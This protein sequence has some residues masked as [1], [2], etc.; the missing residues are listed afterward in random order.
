MSRLVSRAESFERVYEAFENINFAAFDFNT[1][2]QSI[3]D[4]VK[5][6]FP[7]SFNDFIETSEFIALVESFAYIAEQIAYRL[8]INA[9]EN[10][11]STAQRRDSIL[12]LAKL[13][14]YTASRPIP[15]R[16]FT[17][18]SSV[19]TTES[20]VDANG[21]D[22]AGVTIV[23]NDSSNPNWK[24]QFI[25]VINRVLEQEFGTVGPND[26]FQIQDVLFEL[27]NV[28][29]V[30]LTNGVFKYSAN[31]NGSTTPMELVPVEFDSSQGI[32]ERRPA[33]N[34]NFTLLYASDGLGDASETTGFLTL[35]KQG[36]LQRFRTT[37]DGVTPNQFY[38]VTATNV[39]D[40][41]VWL[42][43]VDPS[44][45]E[46]LDLPSPISFRP[47]W[48]G[49]SGEWI[50]VDLA[51]S[52][53]VIFNTNPNRNKYEVETRDNSAVRLIFGDGEFADIPAGTFDIWVRT[54]VNEDIV[55]AQASV[56]NT[57][58]SF[59][60]VDGL[61]R[62]QTFTFTYTLIGSLQNA[63]AAETLDHIRVT[64]PS[65]Y[66]TQDRMVNAEDYNVFML[67]DP[68]ILK[69]RAINRTFAG[70]S[71]YIP[72]HD[73]RESYENVKLFGDDG[74]LYYEQAPVSQVTSI[75]SLDALIA[76]F[77]E[78][79]LSSTDLLT[80]LMANGV[81]PSQIRTFFTT[82]E[83]NRIAA[84]L[85]TPP[86]PVEALLYFKKSNTSLTSPAFQW[87]AV[88]ATATVTDPG[89]PP[90]FID[91]LGGVGYPVDFITEALITVEQNDVLEES[92]TV[93]R[94]SLR[95]IFES[96]ETQFWNTNDANAIIDYDTLTSNIDTIT[97]LKANVDFARNSVLSQNW[98]YDVL[99]QETV[100]SGPETGLPDIHR[101]S[102][103]PSDIN[104]DGLPDN[105]DPDAAS[106]ESVA[107]IINYKTIMDVSASIE[108]FTITFPVFY[109]VSGGIVTTPDVTVTSV[110]GNPPTWQQVG[111]P[112]EISNTIEILEKGDGSGY[113]VVDVGGNKT[114]TSLTGL[115]D[116]IAGYQEIEFLPPITGTTLVAGLTASTTYTFTV[117]VD[118][119]APQTISINS[120]DITNY[121]SLIGQ[122]NNDLVG[123]IANIIAGNIR[124]TSN[125]TGA[126]SSI[127]ITDITVFALFASLADPNAISS[128]PV[129][130]TSAFHATV[131][132]PPQ[133]GTNLVAGLT[134]STTYTLNVDVDGGGPQLISINSDDVTDYSSLIFEINDDLTGAV[135]T[136]QGYFISNST[137][138][139]ASVLVT[140]GSFSPL[141]AAITDPH[142]ISSMPVPGIMG[143]QDVLF[144][145]SIIGTD[146]VLGLDPL[147]T[148]TFTVA[149]DSGAPQT[150]SINGA[151]VT[152]Y[153]SL[154]SEINTDLG[155]AATAK[156]IGYQTVIVS[157][158][159][160]GISYTFLS[161]DTYDF[162]VTIDGGPLQQL[163][164]TTTNSPGFEIYVAI[165]ALMNAVVVGGTVTYSDA[166]SA[167]VVTSNSTGPVST[168]L[169]A[170]GT[171]GSTGGD[172]FAAL[173]V[174]DSKTLAFSP[175]V[176]GNIRITSNTIGPLSSIL[177]TDPTTN[178][179][180]F[181]TISD[182]NTIGVAVPGSSTIYTATVAVDGGAP[183]LVSVDGGLAQTYDDLLTEI[184]ADL[185]GAYAV[186]IG[187]N[188]HII[189]NS[190]GL[191]STIA[192]VNINLFSSLTGFIAIDPAVPG[193]AA[194]TTQ[195]QIIVNDYVYF[196][197]ASTTDPWFPAETTF[198]SATSFID[199]AIAGANLWRRNLGRDALNFA[200]FHFAP[201]Y[202]LVDPAPT[203]IIDT[204]IITKGYFLQ[205]KNFLEDPLA[206]PPDTPTPLALRQAYGYLLN[207]KM[208]SDQVILLPG[209]F[210][211]LFG[212]RAPAEL[213]CIFRVIRSPN[214]LLTD[215]Q[216]KTTIVSV[217]RNFFDV[218][219]WQ[220][221]ETFFFTELAAA[222][223]TAL[224]TEISSVV[225]VPT[226]PTN[227]FGDMF[228]VLAREDEVLYP[229]IAATQIE[230]VAGYTATNLRLNA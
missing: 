229:D 95:L 113:Q 51:H 7:E 36:T 86:S 200:W 166:L 57:T 189:S 199:D 136:I 182:P 5:L 223:H 78:P 20:I 37:F 206:P 164:I 218:T 81:P 131:F 213:Q 63:S 52:Q 66:Y 62:T 130:G 190:V 144:F 4:Y 210:K 65:V 8:D 96:E 209:K 18:I 13:I 73:P 71:K 103:L 49:I 192:I 100:E 201:R 17:K 99:G 87:Y 153:F 121:N 77:I 61:G 101:L 90:L 221:G 23:W 116:S 151:A 155:P 126:L 227:Q 134:A 203:N 67:Q 107:D 228:Q 80:Q 112:N 230:I 53:N 1:I 82:D 89:T 117:A 39:N 128:V 184:S 10:F 212:S 97:V 110:D 93:T 3:L 55:V 41:D 38:D 187:G 21:N 132:N 33:N 43:N 119:G 137:S 222:I 208:I 68:S 205:L 12:R 88:K 98:T 194:E 16:G 69:L 115:A 162:D 171:F 225:L 154:L 168:V 40:I 172:L 197:R 140:D 70:D 141:S 145:G 122:I 29:L 219:L 9:H 185:T 105:L 74:I 198:E 22:L 207:N 147:N 152:D 146:P 188:I 58:S 186:L 138:P 64:A 181:S 169:V 45:G 32:I 217:V 31:V 109:I 75:I 195:L 15:A 24:D 28:N 127:L 46:T 92:Y 47:S 108:P 148:Y 85:T 27:Y 19:T 143:Y 175:P 72:W 165:A 2:K 170:P 133:L 59:T 183:Q 84:A 83:K 167:F 177:I 156:I 159:T 34:S 25:L 102:V 30:P 160:L 215:N 211:L 94:Q 142:Q 176:T 44:T 114:L 191:T 106:L 180:L 104:N 158:V 196:T 111:D 56:V 120:D 48:V 129:T 193:S 35:T 79:L 6:F 161:A 174:A 125:T 173:A 123:A 220:F 54:S 124:I 91:G 216:V 163:S 204:A 50:Q 14:S 76:N 60:Y 178:V 226:F 11:I 135:L 157:P 214:G 118:G 202:H 26:R 179:T 224:P 42:N 139:S 150:I 149:V